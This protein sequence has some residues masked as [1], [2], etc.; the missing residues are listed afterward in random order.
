MNDEVKE[1][2]TTEL[3]Y[4]IIPSQVKVDVLYNYIIH[5]LSFDK[6]LDLYI[7]LGNSINIGGNK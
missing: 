2:P 3:L 1:I 5:E 6:V 4:T 7:L